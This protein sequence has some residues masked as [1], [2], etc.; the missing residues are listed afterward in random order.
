[1]IIAKVCGKT[2]EEL[3]LFDEIVLTRDSMLLIVC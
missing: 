1:M 2:V 3:P